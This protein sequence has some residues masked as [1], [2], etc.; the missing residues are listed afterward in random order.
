MRDSRGFI[1]MLAFIFMV[2]LSLIAAALL[3]MITY[4]TRDS[5]AHADDYRLLNLAEAGVALAVREIRDEVLSDTPVTGTADLRSSSVYGT[6]GSAAQMNRVRYYNEG[7]HLTIDAAGAGSYVALNN[8]TAYNFDMNYAGT[9]IKSVRI[10]CRYAKSGSGGAAPR[11]E[12]LYTTNGVFPQAGNSAFDQAVASASYNAAPCIALDITNDRNWTWDVI[13]SPDFRVRARAYSS[14]NRDVYVDYLFLQVTYDIDTLKEAW[15][16]GAYAAFPVSL[17]SG[18]IQSVAITAEQGKI[19]IN[20][21]S[22]VLLR[23]LM[24]ELG[25]AAATA[26]V[27]AAHIADYRAVKPFDSVEELQQVGGMTAAYYNLLKNHVTVYSLINTGVS[28]PAGARAPVNINTASAEALRAVFDPIGLGSGDPARLAAD[29]A[30]A[31]NNAPFTAFYA[32]SA[33]AAD[34]FYDFIAGRSYLTAAERV[35]VLDNADASQLPPA[36][37]AAGVNCATTEF[38]YDTNAFHVESS[39][40]IAGRRMRLKT[41]AGK[42]GSHTFTAY[43]G[44]P[45]PAGYRRES[46]E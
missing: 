8:N 11:L 29:I 40:D 7:A 10:G 15:A 31:R 39:S 33:A 6:A 20:T 18:S 42:S 32:A 13:N 28:R 45:T 35:I 3:C 27:L 14:N 22:Q 44:D 19:H 2:S 23:Y 17:G 43:A 46:F 12:I 38:S 24:Q 4:E 26:N 9:I 5:G 36:A 25:I 30:A 41:I 16:T 21:A 34:D 37:G 1:L